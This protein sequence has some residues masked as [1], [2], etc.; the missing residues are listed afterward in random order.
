MNKTYPPKPDDFPFSQEVFEEIED[1][2]HR[3]VTIT[4]YNETDEGKAEACRLSEYI[5][6]DAYDQYLERVFARH[7]IVYKAERKK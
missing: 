7:G 6:S 5:L 4:G 1:L 2:K 3:L